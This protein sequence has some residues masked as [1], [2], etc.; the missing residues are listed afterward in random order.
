MASAAAP[1]LRFLTSDIC[2]FAHRAWL[3]LEF[4]GQPYEKVDVVRAC[5]WARRQRSF[6]RARRLGLFASRGGA[7]RNAAHK[8]TRCRVPPRATR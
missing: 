3:A 7:R 4:A 5:A 8:H 2:P 6:S 1:K